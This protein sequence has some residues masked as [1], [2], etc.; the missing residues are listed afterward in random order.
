MFSIIGIVVV[1]GAVIAGY[2]MEHGNMSVLMQPA[3]LIIIL[4]AA[5]GTVLVANP[6]HI[7]KKIG[8]GLVGAFTGSAFTKQRY[9]YYEPRQI[10]FANEP[11]WLYLAM[12]FPGMADLDMAR[13]TF[14]LDDYAR[15]VGELVATVFAGR[16]TD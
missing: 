12:Q 6:L 4:G 9:G 13:F 15:E 3:E 7:L 14:S 11:G 16:V 5:I 2:L 1:F 8:K 10:D